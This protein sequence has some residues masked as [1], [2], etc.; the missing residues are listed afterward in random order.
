MSVARSAGNALVPEFAVRDCAASRDFYCYILGFGVV[1]AR[2]EE[3][4]VYLAREGAELML[5][6]I[7][8]GR[9]F[10]DAYMPGTTPFGRGVNLQIRVAAL[11]PILTAVRQAGIVPAR[12][13]EDRWYRRDTDEIG[14]RQIV[15]A[16]LD[17]YLLR[18]Y[19]PLGIRPVTHV[20]TA[21]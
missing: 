8:A 9:D 1:Y 12:P 21:E 6:A 13:L 19:E 17:G 7:G 11:D 15:I 18:F 5:D 16:D 14:H 2:P 10:E 3:G 4:F 20:Q